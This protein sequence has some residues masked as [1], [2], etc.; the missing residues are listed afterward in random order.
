MRRRSISIP[1][2]ETM[3]KETQEQASG[4]FAKA[5]EILKGA[6]VQPA[7]VDAALGRVRSKA[8]KEISQRLCDALEGGGSLE[9]IDKFAKLLGMEVLGIQQLT[10]TARLRKK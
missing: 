7:T 2:M 1:P 5:N 6:P 8:I 10:L 9:S 4:F 3:S